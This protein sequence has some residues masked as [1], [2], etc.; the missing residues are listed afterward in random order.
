MFTKENQ[1]WNRFVISI[2]ED[3]KLKDFL[4]DEMSF[5]IRSISRMKREKN[6]FING[7]VSKPTAEVKKGDILEIVL[8]EEGSQF[9]P[10]NLGV[11]CLYN[12]EDLLIFYKPP[13]MVVHPTKSH[14]EGTLANHVSYFID[15]LDENFKIRFV[16]RL[17]MN[18]S[19]IVIVAKNA[20][21]HH[22]LSK[23][24]EIND[25]SK[26][27]LAIVEGVIE[28]DRDTIDLP[29]YRETEDSI[30]RVIDSRGQRAITHYEVL[31]RY[32]NHTL[33]KLKID[34]GRTHQIRVHLS[35]ISNG[36]V[37][38]ELYGV[39]DEALIGRQA[40]HACKIEFNQPRSCDRILVKS[41]LPEDF[42]QLIDKLKYL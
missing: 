42:I 16:N 19:G 33:V 5:S 21:A 14:R 20:Y 25:I 11:R 41:E 24:M 32:K 34:T 22:K 3:C 10:Q 38:D 15:I 29:I 39:V 18:T 40:L 13:F 35:S 17:D 26:N 12:D 23:D 36:I 37:G 6:I 4:I 9:I 27:Y 28:K 2:D 1:K 31:E 7:K 30:T 8:D